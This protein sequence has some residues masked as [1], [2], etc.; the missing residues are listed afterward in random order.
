MKTK[1]LFWAILLGAVMFFAAPMGAQAASS[2]AV[3]NGVPS[4]LKGKMFRTPIIHDKNGMPDFI[5]VA[6]NKTKN[7]R[8][9]NS[10]QKGYYGLIDCQYREGKKNVF[11]LAGRFPEESSTRYLMM[12]TNT[13]HTKFELS[14]YPYTWKKF[15]AKL[16]NESLQFLP[17]KE[18]TTF[19]TWH[20]KTVR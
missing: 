12:V 3:H 9:K 5:Y 7:L 10:G 13:A 1:H 14:T 8:M 19:P 17:Y 6:C 2:T 15:K 4:F 11:E 16:G 20:G 18:F